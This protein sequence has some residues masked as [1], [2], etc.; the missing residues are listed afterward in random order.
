MARDTTDQEVLHGILSEARAGRHE[1]AIARARAAL[2]GGLEHAL[3]LNLAAAGLERQGRHSEAEGLLRRAIE[4]KPDDLASRNALGLCLLRLERSREALEQF[5]AVIARN[6]SLPYAHVNRGNALLALSAAAAARESYERALALDSAQPMALAALA[7]LACG[8]GAYQEARVMAR[9]A[10]DAAPGLIEAVMSLASAELGEGELGLAEARMRRLLGEHALSVLE[11]AHAEGLLGDILD[12]A[13]RPE[14]A[15]GAYC[16]CNEALRRH[17]SGRHESALEYA[18][19]LAGWLER[20]CAQDPSWRR[21]LPPD[22]RSPC[23]HVFV[24]GFPRSGSALVDLVLEGHPQVA[25]IDERELLID[26]VREF[27]GRPEHLERLLSAP[28]EVLERF[29][30]AY[31]E[32]VAATG[33]AAA[34]RILVDTCALNTLKLPL[35]AMLFPRAKILFAGRDPRDIVVSCFRH[36]FGMTAPTYELLTIEGAARYYAAVTRVL[37]QITSTVPLEVCLVRHED[38]VTAFSREMTRVCEF[39]GVEWHP[40][41]GDFALRSRERGAA[42][43]SL[44]ELVRGLGTEGLGAW[45]RYRQFLEPVAAILD[46]W[47]KRFYYGD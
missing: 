27:M 16:A 35:I 33:V 1:E 28:P 2:D 12:A 18:D 22:G 10:L 6:G 9:R 29:R 15:F 37:V 32:R 17:H 19:A 31:F 40:A 43:P 47:V 44:P 38:L 4:L 39:L 42:V 30:A 34:G 46:P 26:S 3:V 5:E 45:R 41:M 13:G 8:R 7:S 25:S 14:E 21:P 23:R 20:S 11:R 36:R 24:L